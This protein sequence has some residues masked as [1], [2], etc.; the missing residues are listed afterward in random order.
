MDSS[1]QSKDVILILFNQELK[2]NEILFN[3]AVSVP[4]KITSALHICIT[5]SIR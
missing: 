2:E 3:K 5:F 1:R 4:A